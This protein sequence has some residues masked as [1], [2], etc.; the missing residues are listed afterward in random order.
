MLDQDIRLQI[1]LYVAFPIYPLL[2]SLLLFWVLRAFSS[3]SMQ[4]ITFL[5][6]LA[7]NH[8][9]S[10]LSKKICQQK[11]PNTTVNVTGSGEGG[12]FLPYEIVLLLMSKLNI[13]NLIE[14]PGNLSAL[15][16]LAFTS[17][18]F[19]HLKTLALNFLWHMMELNVQGTEARR[20]SESE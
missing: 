6:I 1:P 4:S 14:M 12:V 7:S 8:T 10:A 15:L 13:V 11:K 19:N 20:S 5:I 17:T 18:S 3:A 2:P 16:W 9:Y